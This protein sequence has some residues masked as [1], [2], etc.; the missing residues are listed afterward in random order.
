[1]LL[2]DGAV[3]KYPLVKGEGT[4][5]LAAEKAIYDALGYHERIVRCLGFTKKGLKL[6]SASQGSATQ[7]LNSEPNMPKELRFKW[8][9]QASEALA[10]IHSKRVIHC[11]LHTYK[12]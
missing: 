2:E 6:Q 10:Y 12:F 5:A 11:D 8:C 3:L 9:R 7:R 1:M 4:E